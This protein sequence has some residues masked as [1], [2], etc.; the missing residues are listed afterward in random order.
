[1][2]Y[3]CEKTN[4][5][6]LNAR[7]KERGNN[8]SLLKTITNIFNNK[9]KHSGRYIE[10]TPRIKAAKEEQDEYGCLSSHI[11]V[12]ENGEEIPVY[13]YKPNTKDTIEKIETM[14]TLTKEPRRVVRVNYENDLYG[15]RYQTVTES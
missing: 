8:M 10:Y 7:R 11:Y 6:V 13:Y 4:E 14:K 15:Y 1:M 3:L 9:E 5:E 2:H 12:R